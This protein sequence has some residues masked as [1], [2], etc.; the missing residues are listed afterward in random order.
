[1][2]AMPN[3]LINALVIFASYTIGQLSNNN[4]IQAHLTAPVVILGPNGTSDVADRL[5]CADVG[6]NP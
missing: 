1:M 2:T 6:R 5:V 4:R 3:L